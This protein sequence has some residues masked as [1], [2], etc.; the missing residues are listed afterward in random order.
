MTRTLGPWVMGI[1]AGLFWVRTASAEPSAAD[2]ATARSLAT[3]GYWALH[4]KRYAEAADRFSRADSLV[5]APTLTL[6]L[7]R[8]LV[9]IGQFVEAQ[10]RYELIIREG[11]DPKAPPSWQ[12]AFTDAKAELAALRPRLAW[13]TITVSGGN[14]AHVTIDGI[15]VPAAAIGVRRAINP[16]AHEFAVGANGFVGN[17]QA[18]ALTE[19]QEGAVK[20][21][22][23]VDPSQ[24]QAEPEPV[25]PK[26]AAAP[27]APPARNRTPAY[28]A[29]GVAGVGL[30][31]GGVTGALWLQKR[32]TLEK[33]CPDPEHCLAE[34][35]D[36]VSAYHTLGIIAPTAF[37]VGAA[38]LATGITLWALD[39]GSPSTSGRGPVL[40]PYVGL[41]SIG[42]R[43]SF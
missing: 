39:S 28:V 3:E 13:V 11:I 32:S 4:D 19:G 24:Q 29:F 7:A 38:G 14:D 1:A 33:H 21:E 31:A 2:R 40:R 20:L 16:G 18:L 27:P 43:G 15:E 30:I 26:P 42:A 9:G 35:A 6:D 5:H 25:T 22:L 41:G 17:R 34:D 36:T 8:S 23:H 37:I 12:R 10:E